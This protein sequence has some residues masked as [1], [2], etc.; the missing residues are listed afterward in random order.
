MLEKY[1]FIPL[2][3]IFVVF[4][5]F[6]IAP[7]RKKQKQEKKFSEELKKG[8]KVVTKSGMHGKVV[9]LNDKDNTCVIET[10][11]GKIK[12]ERSALS[13]EMSSKLN[14]PAVIEKK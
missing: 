13:L 8:D 14:A 7:Q 10:L 12:F 2:I 9:E 5:F 3:A 11:A 1:P 4:Y 6:M